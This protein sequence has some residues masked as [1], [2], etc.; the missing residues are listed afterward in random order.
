MG[1]RPKL[2]L[3]IADAFFNMPNALIMGVGMISV[4]L[5][6]LKFWRER[7]VWAPQYLSAGTLM[8]PKVSYSVLKWIWLCSFIDLLLMQ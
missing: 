1:Y 2:T 6:I 8:G 3:T 7:C 5:A 4:Y